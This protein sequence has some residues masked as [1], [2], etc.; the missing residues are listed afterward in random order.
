MRKGRFEKRDGFY[1]TEAHSVDR[2]EE[3]KKDITEHFK[4]M[5]TKK[6]DLVNEPPHYKGNKFEVIDIIEDFNLGF[7][8][9]NAVKY[10]LRCEK[11]GNKKQDLEKAIWY[12]KREIEKL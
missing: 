8:L 1:T 6:E 5:N 3:V 10:V 2:I 12:L 4:N 7:R 11:K 9:A